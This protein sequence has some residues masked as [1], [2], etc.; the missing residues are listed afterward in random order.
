MHGCKNHLNKITRKNSR[1]HYIW[2]SDGSYG[3]YCGFTVMLVDFRLCGL[4]L[5]HKP[6]DPFVKVSL[7]AD[8]RAVVQTTQPKSGLSRL[9]PRLECVTSRPRYEAIEH[10]LHP[11]DYCLLKPDPGL[12]EP[13]LVRLGDLGLPRLHGLAA[14]KPQRFLSF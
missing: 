12:L 10:D 3:Q 6:I 11:V 2:G 14:F 4:L 9:P 7:W 13:V 5:G 1:D 8:V